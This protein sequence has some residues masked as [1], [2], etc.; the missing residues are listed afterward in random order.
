VKNHPRS[1]DVFQQPIVPG[2]IRLDAAAPTT[3]GFGTT[4][5]MATPTLD[6]SS[7]EVGA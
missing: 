5:A 1:L 6:A 3:R 7:P 4:E 2:G